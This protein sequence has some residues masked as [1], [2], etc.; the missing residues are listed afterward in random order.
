MLPLDP[1]LLRLLN[2][3][4]HTPVAWI[5]AAR[6]A[7]SWLPALCALPCLW[8][9]WCLGPGWRRALLLTLWSMA[10]AWLAC[11]VI[12]W[13]YPMPRPGQ[14]GM[15]RQWVA[16]RADASFPSMHATIVFAWASSLGWSVAR[17][18]AWV[19]PLAWTLAGLVALSRVVL[20]VHFPSDVLAG[21]LV[22]TLSAALVWQAALRLARRRQ[23]TLHHTEAVVPLV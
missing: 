8:A 15:G 7:S 12:R 20:G 16:H 4:P 21:L 2:A 3:G 6:W 18:H 19:P 17:Q 9:A 13:G 14:L 23:A 5:Q 1:A 10:V 22:G 11:K